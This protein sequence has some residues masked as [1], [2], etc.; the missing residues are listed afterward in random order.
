MVGPAENCAPSITGFTT[1]VTD[2]CGGLTNSYYLE[3]QYTASSDL[4]EVVATDL[5]ED[6]DCDD[7]GGG[8]NSS[9]EDCQDD[10]TDTDVKYYD[11]EL[12]DR[13]SDTPN[14]TCTG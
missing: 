11:F 13:E 6:E 10:D 5:E 4:I 9:N 8:G 2:S 1:D 14:I 7:T 12:Y 3:V